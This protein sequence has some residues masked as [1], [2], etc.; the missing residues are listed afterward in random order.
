[1]LP[2]II[3]R[4]LAVAWRH[5]NASLF[6][7]ALL[8]PP[9][10]C[11]ADMDHHAADWNASRREI[12]FSRSFV[13]KHLWLTVVEV[14]K[15]EMAHQYVSDVLGIED[16]TAH[17]PAFQMICR[18]YAIDGRASGLTK[19]SDDEQHVIDKIKKLLA[20]GDSPNEHESRA[21]LNKAQHLLEE[22]GLHESDLGTADS[23]ELGVGHVGEIVQRRMP[24]EYRVVLCH[25]LTTHFRVRAIWVSSIDREGRPGQQLELVGRRCDL[26][27]AEYVHEF[28]VAEAMRL[29][30]QQTG[31]AR[32]RQDFVEGVMRGHLEALNAEAKS[33]AAR[34]S[35][36]PQPGMVLRAR[37][38][39]DLNEHFTRRY[40]HTSRM[41]GSRRHR[42]AKFV[43][44]LS[45]GRRLTVKQ[46]IAG[47]AR[48]LLGK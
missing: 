34:E 46:P 16:E 28:L 13:E 33:R 30:G 8:I 41:K 25:I 12:R 35:G 20:L 1:M 48:K 40:P 6:G 10:F 15:H 45:A 21:A 5:V 36:R 9:T 37:Q 4:Q 19:R 42:G 32:D 7:G 47:E 22:Y 29:W 38:E 26:A 14:L 27:V 24:E 3:V 11:L 43:E 31:G 23:Q 18:R 17:G 39:G 2:D 44:G